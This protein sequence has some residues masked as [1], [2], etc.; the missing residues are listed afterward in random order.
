MSHSSAYK[1]GTTRPN[2][3]SVEAVETASEERRKARQHRKDARDR[4]PTEPRLEWDRAPDRK[5]AVAPMLMRAEQIDPSAWLHTLRP[6]NGQPDMF[7]SFNEYRE[8]GAARVEWYEHAGNWSNRLIHAD[9]RRAMASL[10]EHEHLGGSVQMVY[11]DPP[12]G[13]DFDAKLGN[14][15]LTR[16]AFID[17]YDRGVH[18]Y[19]DAVRDTAALA[20][21]LL[22][23]SGSFFMQIG[24]VNVHRC[25]MVLD[26]VFGPENRVAT[27]SYAT[28]G[29]W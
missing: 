26:D 7:A 21:E 6:K 14:D 16:R 5:T 18:S 17:T 20:R 25:A 22:T 3:P 23:E 8:P 2:N 28:R 12:Y 1:H 13:M 24:D 4:R 15:T 27:I 10:L 19:L 11:F 29:W 9:A